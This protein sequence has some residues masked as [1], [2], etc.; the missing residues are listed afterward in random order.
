MA[1]AVGGL[2]GYTHGSTNTTID[3]ENCYNTAKIGDGST[4]QGTG[5]I[6]GECFCKQF[7]A[8][9]CWNDGEIEGN[10]SVGG[11]FGHI[12]SNEIDIQDCQN[13]KSIKGNY[14]TGGVIG[15][16]SNADMNIANCTNVET[17]LQK[18]ESATYYCGGIIGYTACSGK[19][20]VI[21][22]CYNKKD[23]TFIGTSYGGQYVGGIVGYAYIGSIEINNCYNEGNVT[24]RSSKL[25]GI[26]GLCQSNSTIIN[27]CYNTKNV[28]AS[29]YQASGY[30]EYIGGIIGA[31]FGTGVKTI[32]KCYN[33]GAVVGKTYVGGIDGT[34]DATIT[35]CYNRGSVN[36]TGDNVSGIGGTIVENCFITNSVVGKTGK[37]AGISIQA[38]SIKNCYNASYTYTT[39]GGT[40]A[41]LGILKP[42]PNGEISNNYF[43]VGPTSIAFY[44]Y[45][46]QYILEEVS[47]APG[48]A[49]CLNISSDEMKER[50]NNYFKTLPD[51]NEGVSGTN[52]GYPTLKMD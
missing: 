40:Y 20:I 11:V 15:G 5:G 12:Y 48:M 3:I 47:S 32:E 33:T 52:D 10:N 6:L 1:M 19:D 45:N 30:C 22:N 37:T 36:G 28:V 51:W 42:T 7:K 34:G 29:D 4:Y 9:D 41:A 44:K 27:N 23:I 17:V 39:N 24:G 2:V 8:K 43:V 21:S 38:T 25:G 50:I 35:N 49:E 46:N 31:N 14:A 18:D 13:K 16:A 26:I